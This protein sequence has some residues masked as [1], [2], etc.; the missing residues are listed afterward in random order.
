MSHIS[1]DCTRDEDFILNNI[2]TNKKVDKKITKNGDLSNHPKYFTWCKC[3]IQLSYNNIYPDKCFRQCG[4]KLKEK[5]TETNKESKNELPTETNKESKNELP[6][7]TNKES[8]NELPT[9]TNKESKNEIST[10]TN[11]ELSTETKNELSTETNKEKRKK[12]Y[13]YRIYRSHTILNIIEMPTKKQKNY[14]LQL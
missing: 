9:E 6:T 4:L 8:K 14:I 10:E 11:K 7:E 2:L 1:I 3:H 13:L 12:I 5:P